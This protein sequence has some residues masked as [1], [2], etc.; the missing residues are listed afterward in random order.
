MEKDPNWGLVGILKEPYG[1]QWAPREDHRRL[2]KALG[3]LFTTS[4]LLPHEIK[5]RHYVQQLLDTFKRMTDNK[6]EIVIDGQAWFGCLSFDVVASL[7]IGQTFGCLDSG[8][9][10]FLLSTIKSFAT[11]GYTQAASRIVGHGNWAH[12][13]LTYLITPRELVQIRTNIGG[14]AQAAI[15]QRLADVEGS[16]H[17]F[18]SQILRNNEEKGHISL[19]EIV[20]NMLITIAAGGEAAGSALTEWAFAMG[21]NRDKYHKL[22]REIR[23][24][25]ASAEDMNWHALNDLPYL[26]AVVRESFRWQGSV[27]QKIRIVPKGGAMIDGCWIPGGAAVALAPYAANHAEANFSDPYSFVPERWLNLGTKDKLYA[28]M[29]FSHGPHDCIGKNLAFMELKLGIAHLIWHFDL[30]IESLEGRNWM[31]DP[32]NDFEHLRAVN[33]WQYPQLWIKLRKASGK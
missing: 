8:D 31:W 22:V 13:V 23:D 27:T 7:C 5:I 20:I 17:D 10:E 18:I 32:K 25:F 15:L 14:R 16:H 1:L 21:C 24:T 12:R 26:H 19:D 30:D 3:I 11:G 9:P 33:T 28:S 6:E 2:R 29:P 4:A